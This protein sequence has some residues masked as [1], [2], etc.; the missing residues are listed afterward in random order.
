MNFSFSD[1]IL[2]L[3][4]SLIVF[5]PNKLPD[6]AKSLGKGLYEFRNITNKVSETIKEESNNIKKEVSIKEESGSND[7]KK[8]KEINLDK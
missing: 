7:L 4:L 2:I 8:E 5:G 3:L 1:I 6:I